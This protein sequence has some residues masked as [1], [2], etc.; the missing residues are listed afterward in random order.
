[1]LRN[2]YVLLACVLFAVQA[3]GQPLFTYG[4]MSVSKD[5]FLRVYKKNAGASNN[6][7]MSDT[8][9]RSYLQLYSLF[10]MKVAEA[11]K[12]HLDTTQKIKTDMANYRRQLAKN[13][14]SD[15]HITLKLIQEAYNRMKEEVRVAHIVISCPPTSDT[16]TPYKMTDSLYKAITAGKSTFEDIARAFSDDRA[17]KEAGGDIGYITAF[18]TVYP[19]ESAAYN[20][21]VGKISKVFR[22]Q[23][24][25]HIVKVL[26]RRPTNGQVK[27][28]QIMIGSPK[29][30]GDD[31]IAAAKVKADNIV[32]EYRKGTPFHELVKKYSDDKYSVNDSGV[33]KPFG[34]GKYTPAYENAAFALKNIGDISEP[35]KTEYGY[36]IIKLLAKYPLASFD[37]LKKNIKHKVEND[38]RA[39]TAK[40][41]FF[42]K[43]KEKNGYKEFQPNVDA[44][45][46]QLNTTIPDTGKDRNTF[47]ANNYTNMKKPLFTIGKK[48][49]TQHDFVVYLENLTHGRI[50]GP[51]MQ[52]L[53]DAYSSYIT[54]EVTEFTEMMIAEENPE[55][56]RLLAEYKEGIML[57]EL[58]DRNVWGRAAKDSVGLKSFFET[59]KGKYMWEAGF[60]GSVY[61]AKDK[62]AK[63]TLLMMLKDAN[64]TDELIVKALN[65]PTNPDRISIQRGRFEFSR[66]R[67]ATP[68]ELN[69]NRLKVTDAPNNMFKIVNARQIFNTPTAKTL[70]EA[71]GYVVAEY[72]EYLEKSWNEKMRREYPVKV[73]EKVFATMVGH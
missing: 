64:V 10:R 48:T 6:S 12:Q 50:N 47:F 23:F 39:Q 27:V 13:Y 37:S 42:V 62:A 61:V 9:L 59:R 8:A 30:R 36:H 57:F 43:V 45:L 58:M 51:K 38:S 72:Q 66:F 55:F 49:G 44:I 11:E 16:I 3:T 73:N 18:Q 71:R 67:E 22:T 56:K 60:E 26:D 32:N 7:D 28:A 63:D 53:K 29:S 33:L 1:M 15:E 4:K 24:G 70:E 2:I 35:I 21:P 14:L 17:T 19:F 52:M 65:S 46:N 68:S 41:Y 40:D 54:N 31:G 5:D 69:A 20:T 34:V 25:Y